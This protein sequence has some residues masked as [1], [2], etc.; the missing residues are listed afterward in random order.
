MKPARIIDPTTL[1]SAKAMARL[2]GF[3]Y[4]MYDLF[5]TYHTFLSGPSVRAFADPAALPASAAFGYRLDVL[6]EVFL[7]LFVA[8]AAVSM[9]GALRIVAPGLALI[10]GALRLVEAALGAGFIL[11]RH[12]AFLAVSHESMFGA[13]SEAERAGLN[14]MI[15]ALYGSSIFVLLIFMGVGATIFFCLFYRARFL[16]RWLAA[17]GVMTYAVMVVLSAVIILHPPFKQHAMMFFIPGALFEWALGFWLLFA[18][19]NTRYWEDMV[20]RADSP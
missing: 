4:L 20:S 11:V 16:P 15:A 7:Y 8:V 9:A 6:A 17:G 12:A 13:F 18:G 1:A 2:S 14:H 10:G 19:I 5:A 3:A